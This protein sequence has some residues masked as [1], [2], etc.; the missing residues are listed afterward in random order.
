[1]IEN[2]NTYPTGIS[3]HSLLD[4]LGAPIL[5]VA[6]LYMPPTA[7]LPVD[8][9]DNDDSINDLQYECYKIY[10]SHATT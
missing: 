8:D 10:F 7:K 6:K 5:M 2:T 3:K 1:M 4:S 9:D